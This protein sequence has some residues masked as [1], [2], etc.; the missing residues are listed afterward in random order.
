[1]RGVPDRSVAMVLTDLPHDGLTENHW[2]C[3]INLNDLWCQIG[4]LLKRNSA[5]VMTAAAPFNAVLMMSNLSW[6]RHEWIWQ[7]DQGTNFLN[8][9]VAPLRNHESVLVFSEGTPVYHPQMEQGK[10]Y[11]TKKTKPS[12]NWQDHRSRS[13]RAKGYDVPVVT[14]NGGRRVPKTV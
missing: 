9:S 3:R 11:K 8:A 7:K 4:R 14:V 10:P 5:A 13:H 6:F 12:T 1:M 2:D